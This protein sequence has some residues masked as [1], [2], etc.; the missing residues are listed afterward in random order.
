M[1]PTKGLRCSTVVGEWTTQLLAICNYMFDNTL[2]IT[3]CFNNF[4]RQKNTL[5][6]LK[7]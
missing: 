7:G 3:T 2:C 4:Y 1:H 6:L 5:V